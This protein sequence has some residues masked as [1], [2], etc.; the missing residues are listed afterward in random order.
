MASS[1]GASPPW[2]G[3]VFPPVWAGAL[4]ADTAKNELRSFPDKAWANNIGQYDGT[5]TPEA[6]ITFFNEAFVTSLP[7]SCNNKAAKVQAICDLVVSSS[8]LNGCAIFIY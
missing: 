7:S 5:L 4:P 3:P 1:F 6:S 2:A 8:E